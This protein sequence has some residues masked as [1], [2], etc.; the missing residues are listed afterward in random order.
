MIQACHDLLSDPFSPGPCRRADRGPSERILF[1][2]LAAMGLVVGFFLI[3]HYLSYSLET[4]QEAFSDTME[5]AVG[6]G[7]FGRRVGF[8]LLGTLGAYGLLRRE[9][10]AWARPTLPVILTVT[11]VAWAVA[12]ATW[13]TAPSMTYRRLFALMCSFVAMLGIAR[14]TTARDLAWMTI[15]AAG[16]FVALGLVNELAHGYFRPWGDEYRFAGTMHP[17]SQATSCAALCMAAV[18]LSDTDRRVRRL[19]WLVAG[20]AFVFLWLTGSR[21]AT[22]A[23]LVS[24]MLVKVVRGRIRVLAIAGPW[25]V[26]GG[27]AVLLVSELCGLDLVG[28]FVD[29]AMMG[30]AEDASALAGRL[31]LWNELAPYIAEHP[32]LGW[33]YGAFWTVDHVNTLSTELAWAIGA[34]HNAYLEL[35]LDLGLVGAVLATVTV[36][37]SI[38]HAARQIRQGDGGYAF[39]FAMLLFAVLCSFTESAFVVP[40]FGTELAGCAVC[41]M[42]F[43]SPP[44]SGL[45]VEVAHA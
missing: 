16:S 4:E 14:Q 11:L 36:L 9:G 12:S 28:K 13:S 31:P 8:L 15:V 25:I 1:R 19:L 6:S 30:R 38:G 29:V 40:C 3:E 20:L 45:D 18:L 43:F 22:A 5:D 26:A 17:N 37:F 23:M 33:G 39:A 24:L 2:W 34:A 27:A 41:H 21:T 44:E 32:L 35:T 42:V 7:M 10:R